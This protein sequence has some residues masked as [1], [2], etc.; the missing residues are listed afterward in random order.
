LPSE[1]VSNKLFAGKFSNLD[2][3]ARIFVI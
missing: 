1:L 2:D 3:F